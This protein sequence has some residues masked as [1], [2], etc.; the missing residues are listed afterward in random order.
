MIPSLASPAD[1]RTV[2]AA[3]ATAVCQ[4]ARAVTGSRTE[5]RGTIDVPHGFADNNAPTR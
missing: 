5:A 2:R 1:G 3:P 4:D